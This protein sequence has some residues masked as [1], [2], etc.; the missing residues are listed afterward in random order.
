MV[1]NP[2]WGICERVAEVQAMLARSR[3]RWQA[4]C[5]GRS[6]EGASRPARGAD[7]ADVAVPLRMMLGMEGVACRPM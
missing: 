2:V 5:R 6:C 4:L 7:A 1:D 3:G